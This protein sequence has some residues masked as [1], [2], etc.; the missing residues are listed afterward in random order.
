MGKHDIFLSSRNI[1]SRPS[2]FKLQT[3]VISRA[4][5]KAKRFLRKNSEP[6]TEANLKVESLPQHEEQVKTKSMSFL[7]RASMKEAVEYEIERA[8]LNAKLSLS[9]NTQLESRALEYDSIQNG[10]EVVTGYPETIAPLVMDSSHLRC[11]TCAITDETVT[12]TPE[13][14]DTTHD[15]DEIKGSTPEHPN[16]QFGLNA[17]R[18]HAV[19]YVIL[20]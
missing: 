12:S 3:K 9:M 5:R 19:A 18:P 13:T 16:N 14:L 2:D 8:E 7:E 15:N 4:I 6:R 10:Q 20:A 17:K 11:A 1:H